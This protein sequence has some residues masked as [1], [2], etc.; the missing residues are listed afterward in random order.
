LQ[1]TSP[2]PDANGQPQQEHD[3]LITIPQRN[4]ALIFMIFV[5]P[6]ADFPQLQP[7]YQAMLKSM[8]F[9]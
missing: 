3:W 2:F 7:A 1:S 9:K 8:Q 4:G 5:A 6:E